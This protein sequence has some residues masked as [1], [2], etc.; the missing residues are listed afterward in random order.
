MIPR[1]GWLLLL[2]F[3]AGN[4]SA[5]APW[6][7]TITA[8]APPAFPNP[9][10]QHARYGFSWSGFPCGTA[11]SR[12]KK[13]GDRLQLDVTARTAGL[14]RALWKFDATNTSVV[15]ASS[16]HPIAVRQFEN[17]RDKKILTE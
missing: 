10:P 4:V 15:D 6:E 16:L 5:T 8:S 12:L 3:W 7:S 13:A 2:L 17:D 11:E 1:K 14:A 9:R